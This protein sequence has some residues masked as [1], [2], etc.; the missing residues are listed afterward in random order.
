MEVAEKHHIAWYRPARW[1]R[2]WWA[3]PVLIFLIC[4]GFFWKIVLTDQYT[5][6][7]GGDMANQILPWMQFQAGE[8][9]KGRFPLWAPYEYG[10]QSLIGQGVPSA[11]YPPDWLFYLMPLRHG[12]MRQGYLHWYFVV[13]H[14]AAALFGYWLCRDLKR[15]Q[16]ASITAG[17]AFS[18]GG[19]MGNSDWPHMIGAIWAPLVFL[20]L[21]RSARGRR[22]LAN[23]VFAGVFLGMSW[24][25]G[26]HQIPIFISLTAVGTWI[27]YICRP[28]KPDWRVARALAV[29]LLFVFLSGALQLLPAYEFGHYSKRWVNAPEPVDWKTPVPYTV[30]RDYSLGPVSILGVVFPGIIRHADPYIG[31]TISALAL[32]AIAVRWRE[33]LVKLFGLITLG[34]L[35]F[36]LGANNVLHGVIYS[37]VPFVEKARSP[38]MAIFIFHFGISVLAAYGIDSFSSLDSPWPL[39]ISKGL[40]ALGSFTLLLFLGIWIAKG[41]YASDDRIALS[42]FI[43]LLL[44]G[45]VYGWHK[46]N[47]RWST[48]A[49]F[50]LLFVLIEQGNET[51]YWMP[52]KDEKDRMNYIKP[53]SENADIINFLRRQ[54]WPVRVQVNSDEIPHNIGDWIGIDSWGFY[55]ASLMENLLRL[56]PHTARTRT[57]F[58]VNFSI[59]KKPDMEG[60]KEVFVGESGLKVYMNTLAMPRVWAVHHAFQVANEGEARRYLQN[61]AFDL[62]K[63]SFMLEPPPK[64]EP[65]DGEDTVGLLRRR[66]NQVIIEADMSCTGMVVLGDSFYPGWQAKVD[67]N[68]AKIYEAY[69]G[70]RGVVVGK[71]KHK[72]EMRY[73]PWTVVLGGS[74][75][76][77]AFLIAGVLAIKQ[78]GSHVG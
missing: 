14:F 9:H 52:H 19:Y 24:L 23:A 70:I 72:V 54:P 75:T 41:G 59:A 78:R 36:A 58:G 1:P 50:A 29:F 51:G 5:W 43:A 10:G 27:Y 31:L 4:T 66:P 67:G 56:E 60:Q 65:C 12:W 71:G 45:L 42:G 40:A 35:F 3:G 49:V 44:A 30:H 2:S 64:L 15:S 69:A 62:N 6:F 25:H 63:W 8:W 57:L 33:P 18:L 38:G 74:L 77:A 16:L 28:G 46:R 13:M 11:A 34:G 47:L 61:P 22:P 48:A 17:C 32:L 53:L 26:H 21:L 37:L 7:Q 76:A 20:F 39:R 73:L 55:G 68:P